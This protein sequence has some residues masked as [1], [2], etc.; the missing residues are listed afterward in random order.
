MTGPG[1]VRLWQQF[2]VEYAYL[3][4]VSL[5]IITAFSEKPVVYY[6]VNI[7]LVEKWVAV[8]FHVSA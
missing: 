8:L 3:D 1:K 4:I 6:T 2:G 7:E 5:V